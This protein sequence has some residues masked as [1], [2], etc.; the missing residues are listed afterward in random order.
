MS[1]KK[2]FLESR[3]DSWICSILEL[4]STWADPPAPT[5]DSSWCCGGLWALL[6]LWLL[7][8]L[9]QLLM[10]QKGNSPVCWDYTLLGDYDL[11]QYLNTRILLPVYG[12]NNPCC[13][14]LCHLHV[15]S[16]HQDTSH[17]L[18]LAWFL[19]SLHSSHPLPDH[20][21]CCP[22]W[23]WT[24]LQSHC[25]GTGPNCCM[26]FWLWCLPHL[27]LEKI[28]T[29]NSPYQLCWWPSVRISLS[30][31]QITPPSN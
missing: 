7:Y 14:L 15:W 22:C 19:Q 24:P 28:K 5:K 17:Q 10:Q 27:P 6:G 11:V 30:N 23:G 26:P 18:A 3:Q 1:F 9:H 31:M 8:H 2:Y 4:F 29:Y 25:G 16:A 13:Y 12:S 21:H 20:L